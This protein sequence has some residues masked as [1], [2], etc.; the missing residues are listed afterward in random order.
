MT[1]RVPIGNPFTA[2]GEWVRGN[3]HTHTTNS[4][5]QMPPEKVAQHYAA[6]GYDFLFYTDHGVVTEPV[7]R[8]DILLLP[9]TEITA[10]CGSGRGIHVI[11]LNVRETIPANERPAAQVAIDA[12]RAQEGLAIAGHPYWSGL[13]LED[14]QP[15]EGLTAI[16]VYNATCETAVGTGVSSVH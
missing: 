7:E 11:G 5:G 12:I 9:G 14:L 10:V 6:G 3:T 8:D 13:T 1:T 2:A 15:L 4:D 16:E